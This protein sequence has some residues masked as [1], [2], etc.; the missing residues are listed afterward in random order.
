MEISSNYLF[1]EVRLNI[2]SAVGQSTSLWTFM[3]Y[4]TQT[5]ILAWGHLFLFMLCV[6]FLLPGISVSSFL[7]LKYPHKGQRYHQQHQFF[8]FLSILTAA[9]KPQPCEDWGKYCCALTLPWRLAFSV[10]FN[11][12]LDV[13]IVCSCFGHGGSGT[14]YG[15]HCIETQSYDEAWENYIF[16]C[17]NGLCME[18][19]GKAK[20][21]RSP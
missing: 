14:Y 11:N 17:R 4:V 10:G 3:S 8:L 21:Q 1:V 19:D 13:L 20:A 6:A 18:Y 2:K 7:E 9:Q 5:H 15:Y 12:F 16:A